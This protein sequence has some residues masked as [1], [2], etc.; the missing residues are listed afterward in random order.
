M[1][2][3][4][5]DTHGADVAV[6]AGRDREDIV[7]GGEIIRHRRSS[8]FIHFA[9]AATFIVCLLTGLP[10]WTPFFTW[11]ATLFGGL[12][13][14]RWLHPW[15]GIFFA[16]SSLV[17]FVHWAGQMTFE[18]G[19][20][21]WLSPKRLMSYLE[22]RDDNTDVGKYNPG[23]KLQFWCA[24]LAAVGLLAS[25]VVM[26]FPTSFPQIVRELS[27]LLHSLTF[28]LF[29]MLITWHVYL[30][31]AAE[32]GTFHSITRGTVTKAWARLHHP[33]WYRQVM[34]LEK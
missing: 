10:I 12:S 30:G 22:Y 8:R 4:S 13:F 20:K 26:W 9:V 29:V 19:E 28:I 27:I 21:S 23:Q 1:S 6:T 15:A 14:C 11:M 25:G 7:V 32:P 33:K 34:G 17:M 3:A 31:T 2:V 24:I 16:V 5:L 18:P